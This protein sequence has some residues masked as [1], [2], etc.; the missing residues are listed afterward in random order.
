LTIYGKCYKIITL[1]EKKLADLSK[2]GKQIYGYQEV[3]SIIA[4]LL[5]IEY[6]RMSNGRSACFFYCPI[7]SKK[8]THFLT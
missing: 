3:I 8:D 4:R 7:Q 2:D 6:T 1:N 5:F